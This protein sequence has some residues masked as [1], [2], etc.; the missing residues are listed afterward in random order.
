MY[1]HLALY[2]I[3]SSYTRWTWHGE[4]QVQMSTLVEIQA[5]HNQQV[6]YFNVSYGDPTVLN[7]L[8]YTFSFA[9]LGYQ[10]NVVYDNV[11][12][13]SPN[14]SHVD[15]NNDYDKYNML[16]WEIQTLLYR[17]SEHTVLGT[18]MEQMRIKNKRGKTNVCFDEEMAFMKK[19]LPKGNSCP[20]DLEE[21]KNMLAD[22]GLEI[23][24]ID[25]CVNNCKLY[26]KE[27]KAEDECPHC[28]E[29]RY[30]AASTLSKQKNRPIPRKVLRYFS[31][32]PRLQRLYMSSH[33]QDKHFS[34]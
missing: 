11:P 34:R 7:L 14:V 10:K 17:D 23:Q 31:L 32:V 5:Q 33:Y 9:V 25:A 26:Y 3:C 27:T 19:V 6:G 18:V 30:Q 21:V 8:N 1:S 13:T 22:P 12:D 16:V 2:G 15:H 29:P 28:Y 24:K 4:N 20:A